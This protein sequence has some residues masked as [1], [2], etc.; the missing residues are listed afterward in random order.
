VGRDS[1]IV[2]VTRYRLD[3][4]GIESIWGDI[5][6]NNPDR[7]WSPP[8]LQYLV[9]PMGKVAEVKERVRLYLYTLWAFVACSRVDFAYYSRM[10]YTFTRYLQNNEHYTIN[11]YVY[12]VQNTDMKNKRCHRSKM[13]LGIHASISFQS[14]VHF[15]SH[16]MLKQQIGNITK[17]HNI[18]FLLTHADGHQG[19]RRLPFACTVLSDAHNKY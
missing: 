8:S 2:I 5:F 12:Y 7:P 18:T 10:Q 11:H 3:G 16:N 17:T 15:E 4:T 6:R 1:V 19:V 9:F 14:S 13:Y